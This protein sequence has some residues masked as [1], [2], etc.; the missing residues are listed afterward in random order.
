MATNEK[1]IFEKSVTERRGLRASVE[2]EHQR[3]NP[4][5]LARFVRQPWL[6]YGIYLFCFSILMYLAGVLLFVPRYLIGPD[7]ALR[8]V[9]QW[10]VW[11]SGVPMTMGFA[12]AGIDLL[13]LFD[14]KRPA[15][16]YRD[17]N[18]DDAKVVVVL[19]A[20]NDEE[21]I[22]EAVRDFKNH[23]RVSRVIVVSNNST[24]RTEE[25]A[26]D[27][28][29]EA[30]NERRQGYGQCVY[31][32]YQEALKCDDA[33]F[34]ILCEGDRT[35]RARDIDKLIAFAPHADIVNGTRIVE[36]LRA[37]N[38]QLTT[39]M[40]FGNLFVAKL[41]EVKHLGRSTLT[42]VGATYKLIRRDSL[43]ALMPH[44]NPDVNLEF[45]AHF[46]DVALARGAVLIECPV[47]FHERVGESKGGNTDN[48]RAFSVGLRMMLGISFGW[49]A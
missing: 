38:T 45:N 9:A 26:R 13:L 17:E 47:T 4:T 23:P 12:L 29:G 36:M 16:E 34:I 43:L 18:V 48:V 6:L 2:L 11:F 7:D 30:V 8:P 27:A 40:F 25:F 44:L 42:D 49:R 33:E 1:A 24:D 14:H 37:Q 15:R 46:M 35:F 5:L 41:L 3:S 32:S 10:L 21:S 31:R 39:F 28:G 22:G 19:T 20:Y